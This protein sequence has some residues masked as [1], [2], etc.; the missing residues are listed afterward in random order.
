LKFLYIVFIALLLTS[1]ATKEEVLVKPILEV[2]EKIVQH[3]YIEDLKLIPQDVSFYT[4]N[5]QTTE[6]GSQREYEKDYFR[7]W[8]INESN[9]SI[10]DAMWAHKI[11]K[12]G[13]TYGENLQRLEQSFF[14]NMLLNANYEKYLSV[15]KKALSLNLLNIR[16]FPTDKVIL[17]DPN[18]AGEGFPFDYLQNSTIAANK[19]LLISHYSKDREWVFVE[20]SFAYGWVKSS[21]VVILDEKYTKLWQQAEQVHIV[22]DGVPIYSP[23]NEFLFHSRVGMM[24]ALIGEDRDTYTVLTIAKYKEN[25]PL[26][27]K[28]KISKDITHKGKLAFNAQ[29]I[30]KVINELSK[31][32]YGWGGMY[33]QRDCSSTLRDFYAS[34]A[35]WLPRNSYQQSLIGEVIKLDSL[36]DKDKVNY[37]KENAVAF[38]TLVYKKGHIGLYAGIVEGKII[39]YQNVWGVKTQRDGVEGRFIIGKPIFSTL[40][41]G[42]NL[43]DYDKDA[44]ML[45]KLKSISTL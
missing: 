36:S 22:K 40:E 26:Y 42:S 29:N 28:S 5:I 41:V 31:S 33:E 9:L 19:P 15:N 25:R 13:N 2:K 4:Q 24:L 39:I 35:V 37:I 14:D 7:I 43:S 12:V 30:D 23:N 6:I 21:E 17:R 8:N 34:F 18:K 16:A 20:A 3:E 1:C 44:S 32:H 10:G 45:H 27:L 38:R 11:Y